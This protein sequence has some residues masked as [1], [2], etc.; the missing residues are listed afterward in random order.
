MIKILLGI[1]ITLNVIAAIGFYIIYKYSLKGLAK[2]IENMA[3]KNLTNF[4]IDFDK[5]EKGDY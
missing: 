3:L 1:S 4:D 5:F 2:R